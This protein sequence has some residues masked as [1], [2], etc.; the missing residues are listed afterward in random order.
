VLDRLDRPP[1]TAVPDERWLEGLD[2]ALDHLSD[3]QRRAV[4]A[5]VVDDDHYDA[6]AH[7]DGTTEVVARARVSRGRSALRHRLSAPDEDALR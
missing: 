5:R 7:R 2:E 3:D 6:I 4:V 1:A